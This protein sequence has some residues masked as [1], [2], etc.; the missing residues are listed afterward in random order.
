MPKEY[1]I[2]LGIALGAIVIGVILFRFAG[3]PVA[4][5][6]LAYREDAYTKGNPNASVVV[7]EFADYQCPACRS[8]AA[9]I[10]QLVKE[11]PDEIRV[12]FRHFPLSMH[13]L[14]NVSAEA[15]EAAGEQGKFWEMSSLLFDRQNEWGDT[16][17]ALS[18]SQ[19]IEKFKQYAR[20]LGLDE[21]KFSAAIE[22]GT[23]RTRINDDVT[24]GSAAGV[25]STPQ[26]FVNTTMIEDLSYAG[27][28]A[29]I[30]KALGR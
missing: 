25:N 1:K 8:A 3:S 10:D 7:T 16:S 13:P 18:R 9:I 23:F 4:R 24:A 20:Q 28:K 22:D 30:D 5:E 11:Y 17:A 15:A 19:A 26:F 27:L 6:Q 21:P 2:L 29:E 12:E 14:A